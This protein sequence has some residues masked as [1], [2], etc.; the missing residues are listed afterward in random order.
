M[1]RVRRQPVR[2][3]SGLAWFVSVAAVVGAQT[4]TEQG[5]RPVDPR[6]ADLD[7]LGRSLRVIEPGLATTG[8][9]SAIHQRIMPGGNHYEQPRTQRLYFIAQGFM[10]EYDR[11]Q[12]VGTRRGDVFATIPPN[13]VFHIT[14]PREPTAP[15]LEAPGADQVD[16]RINGRATEVVVTGNQSLT[17]DTRWER[18]NSAVL[19]QRA[20][21]VRRLNQ[22]TPAP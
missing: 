8:E 18:Y 20:V 21:V 2:L 13:T 17:R 11:S 7:P 4:V 3:V 16:G 6:V 19:M 22:P 10:A 15:E 1:T 9:R 12:Y 14:P 5:F